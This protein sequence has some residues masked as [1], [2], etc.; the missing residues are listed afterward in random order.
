[1]RAA[2]F[3]D[4]AGSTL[5][6]SSPA[7]YGSQLHLAHTVGFGFKLSVS[8]R[9]ASRTVKFTGKW[10]ALGA[11]HHHERSLTCVHDLDE[12]TIDEGTV[13]CLL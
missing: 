9:H 10:L 6:C 1:V 5:S 7:Y 3:S 12:W 13:P 11:M 4:P 2:A 8:V